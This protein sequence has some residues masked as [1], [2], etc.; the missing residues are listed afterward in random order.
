MIWAYSDRHIP[1]A[2]LLCIHGQC[3][4]DFVSRKII[5]H[6]YVNTRSY[7]SFEWGEAKNRRNIQIH[8]VSF[9]SAST[10][11]RLPHLVRLDERES[12]GEDCWVAIGCIGP[13][14]GVIVFT[15]RG[16]DQGNKSIRIISARKASTREVELY[17]QKI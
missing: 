10:L 9:S 3:D 8:G 11:F 1:G 5:V 14:I 13:V 6:T 12:Y 15:E 17:E 7:T 2:R 4:A 16:E